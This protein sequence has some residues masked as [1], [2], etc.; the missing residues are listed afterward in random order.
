MRYMNL[1]NVSFLNADGKSYSVKDFREIPDYNTKTTYYPISED[2]VDEI[3]SRKEFFGSGGEW[4]YYKIIEHNKVK[5]IE[6]GFS[7]SKLR[8]LLIPEA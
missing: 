1:E 8:P 4:Q 7:I 2:E 5:F 3:A 6:N